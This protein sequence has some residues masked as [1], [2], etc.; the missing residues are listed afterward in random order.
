MSRLQKRSDE[1]E[2]PYERE[3]KTNLF[4]EPTKSSKMVGR[5]NAQ[6]YQS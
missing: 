5:H 3:G 4:A 1:Q 6:K 2:N